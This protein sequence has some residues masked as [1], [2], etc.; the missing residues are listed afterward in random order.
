MI[1]TFSKNYLKSFLALTPTSSST[2][3]RVPVGTSEGG[4]IGSGGAPIRYEF[5]GRGI[6]ALSPWNDATYTYSILQLNSE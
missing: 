1:I 2:A 3:E 4:G 5:T 6:N